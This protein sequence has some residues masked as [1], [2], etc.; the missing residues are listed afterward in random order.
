MKIDLTL[1]CKKKKIILRD[2]IMRRTLRQ[3][4]EKWNGRNLM[5][6]QRRSKM[7]KGFNI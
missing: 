5:F 2:L 6:Q 3:K 1:N 7:R 4:E